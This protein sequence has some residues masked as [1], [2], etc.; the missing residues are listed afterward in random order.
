MYRVVIVDGG[1][2]AVQ[3]D[4]EGCMTIMFLEGGEVY[5]AVND[6]SEGKM[7]ITTEGIVFPSRYGRR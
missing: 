1:C 2:S 3:W 6:P 4:D 7:F 5:K